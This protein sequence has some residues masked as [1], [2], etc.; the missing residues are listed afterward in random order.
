M[1]ASFEIK[2]CPT[3]LVIAE[4]ER[5]GKKVQTATLTLDVRNSTDHSRTG[6]IR[7]EP[8][9]GA[10]PEWFTIEGAPTTSPLEV[11]QDFAG[12]GQRSVR[13]NLTVSAGEAPKSY[14]FNA[15][16][17]AEDDPDNDFVKGPNVAFDIAPWTVAPPPPPPHFPWWVLA[18]AA[19]LVLL[20][21]GV[22]G[23]FEFSPKINVAGLPVDQAKIKLEKAGKRIEDIT[24]VPDAQTSGQ[25]PNMVVRMEENGD[26]VKLIVD[27]GVLVPPLGPFETTAAAFVRAGF[28]I[29]QI[30]NENRADIAPNTVTKS[31][32]TSGQAAQRGSRVELWVSA[33][34][35]CPPRPHPCN[36]LPLIGIEHIDQTQLIN[37][38][39]VHGALSRDFVFSGSR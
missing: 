22:V 38:L 36:F 2:D 10:K 11:E 7:I 20:V 21:A 15:I 9:S 33:R 35:S 14:L 17:T 25:A 34:P 8:G 3:K 39:K 5:A 6:R 30:T 31:Q 18:V 12:K 26:K 4:A 27:P 16:V 23:Y 32:P 37:D 13:V 28:V 1:M 24:V 29:D 19:V